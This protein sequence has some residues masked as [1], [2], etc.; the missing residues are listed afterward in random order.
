M[1]EQQYTLLQERC[2]VETLPNGLTVY[3]VPKP[4][5]HKTFA[6]LA[7]RFGGIDTRFF[8]GHRV[9]NAPV[10]TAHFLKHSL[11][12]TPE[13][14]VLPQFSVGGAVVD[15]FT[16]DDMTGFFFTCTEHFERH[17]NTLLRFVL[18]PTFT[19]KGVLK[20]Q[21]IIAREIRMKE[22]LPDRQAHRNLMRELYQIHPIRHGVIGDEKSISHI[23]PELLEVC[24]KYFYH[25]SNLV[26]CVA[27][28]VDPRVVVQAA[29]GVPDWELSRLERDYGEEETELAQVPETECR[30]DVSSTVF[31]LGFK[32][33]AV[34][35]LREE[36]IGELAAALLSGPSSPLY[37]KLYR[38]GI[39][40]Q[41]FR[42]KYCSGTGYAHFEFSGE[43]S[44][45]AAVTEE[46]L[47]EA[48]RIV[49]TGTE[50]AQ[51]DRIRK[52]SYGRRVKAFN[53][54][55]YICTHIASAHFNG[56]SY[57]EFPDLYE[58]I[59]IHDVKELIQES[60]TGE[61]C[62]LSVVRPKGV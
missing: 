54:M 41:T 49:W 30:M 17:L 58:Q 21:E 8:V 50:S 40:N 13:G 43:S 27:G 5:Y 23:T 16:T 62:T 6:M 52:A 46:I 57:F 24:H 28:D 1:K 11:F 2:F 19:E 56:E 15:G 51:F 36:L 7:S 60:I 35:G 22:D 37:V 4:G 25:P 53:S 47:G 45:P 20:E 3:V 61:R 10:G 14:S 39:L 31:S 9:R 29:A 33:P 42:A 32:A 12:D 48:I 18:N 26:L 59:S 55:Q 44:N 38:Q 34:T